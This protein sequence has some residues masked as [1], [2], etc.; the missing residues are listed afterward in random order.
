MN[1]RQIIELK[2]RRTRKLKRYWHRRG[3]IEAFKTRLEEVLNDYLIKRKAMVRKHADFFETPN[4]TTKELLVTQHLF[5]MLEVDT[6]EHLVNMFLAQDPP[7]V[8]VVTSSGK[9]VGVEVTELVNEKAIGY[10]I[11]GERLKYLK[12]ILSWNADSITKKL[13]NIVTT[14]AQKCHKLPE[15]FDELVL[16]IFTDEPRLDAS[17]IENSIKDVKF[18]GIEAFQSVYILTSRD[19]KK[20][21]KG[22]LKIGT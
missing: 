7:D 20:Q 6:N 16:L 9:K 4:K 19:P 8:A 11:K 1:Y 3:E 14:K 18:S 17:I 13:Q 21:G 12:E 2:R 22:L 15:E 5:Q 10:D